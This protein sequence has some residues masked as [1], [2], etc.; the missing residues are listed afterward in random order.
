MMSTD[1]L[2]SILD[3]IYSYLN[4]N[5]LL[6]GILRQFLSILWD[7]LWFTETKLFVT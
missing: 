3:A 7:Y 6:L 5:F 1:E 2:K 4:L